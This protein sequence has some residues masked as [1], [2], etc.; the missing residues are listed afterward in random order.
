MMLKSNYFYLYPVLYYSSFSTF[1]FFSISFSVF[2]LSMLEHRKY[3]MDGKSIWK[4]M[5]KGGDNSSDSLLSYLHISNISTSLNPIFLIIFSVPSVL[6]IKY[7][8]RNLQ[9]RRGTILKHV[10]ELF[11]NTLRKYFKN[12]AEI[13]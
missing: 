7:I 13:F 2:F 12:V 11:W 4:N 3:K 10:A 8:S 9:T 1:C 5:V 6:S